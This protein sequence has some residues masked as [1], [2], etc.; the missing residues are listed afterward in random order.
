MLRALGKPLGKAASKATGKVAATA[1]KTEVQKV[2]NQVSDTVKET[3][4]Q[5][6]PN[7]D[8]NSIDTK[9][10]NF[11][12]LETKDIIVVGCI[13]LYVII[14]TALYYQ[15]T[16]NKQYDR[17]NI[18][19]F[20]IVYMV[21]VNYMNKSSSGL[22]TYYLISSTKHIL[23]ILLLYEVHFNVSNYILKEN[24]DDLGKFYGCLSLYILSYAIIVYINY[25]LHGYNDTETLLILFLYAT[26]SY[27]IGIHMLQLND[28]LFTIVFP[29]KDISKS[30][31]FNKRDIISV[32][33][34]FFLI[35]FVGYIIFLHT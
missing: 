26:M 10:L 21:V 31:K 16:K 5:F 15:D 8:S 28:K 30:K 35:L 14:Y 11:Q 7:I 27:V 4:E 24:Y 25:N 13:I 17:T 23:I 19:V 1:A 29:N 9:E 18:I 20:S 22:N 34:D 3:L 2:I 33:N 32:T 12:N 6:N